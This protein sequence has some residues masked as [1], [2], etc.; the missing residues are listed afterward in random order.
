MQF[1]PLIFFLPRSVF[2]ALGSSPFLLECAGSMA[3]WLARPVIRLGDET[4]LRP[5][6]PRDGVVTLM[7]SH[8]DVGD[9]KL[10]QFKIPVTELVA[11]RACRAMSG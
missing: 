1:S 4:S 6:L 11:G 8:V 2:R 5:W 3:W 10:S 7:V 9:D